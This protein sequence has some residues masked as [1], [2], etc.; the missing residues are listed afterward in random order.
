V[1]QGQK[2]PPAAAAEPAGDGD[3]GTPPTPADS[4]DAER[5]RLTSEIDELKQQLEEAASAKTE[6]EGRVADL[7]QQLEQAGKAEPVSVTRP[8]SGETAK[9]TYLGRPELLARGEDGEPTEEDVYS[10]MD[11]WS[12]VG[13]V[14]LKVGESAIVSREKAEQLQADHPDAFD[15]E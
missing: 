13:N 1:A 3:A 11:P 15:V 2:K 12:D 6:L 7:E 14:N 9:V 10:G 4:W 5:E 8:R